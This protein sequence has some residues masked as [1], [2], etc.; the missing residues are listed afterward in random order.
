M[1]IT[2]KVDDESV[3]KL[4]AANSTVHFPCKGA[5]NKSDPVEAVVQIFKLSSSGGY[6]HAESCVLCPRLVSFYDGQSKPR[7]YE[8]QEPPNTHDKEQLRTAKICPY[9]NI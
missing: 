1:D 3:K 8:G 9:L 5:S 6:I 2:I 4:L 7:C